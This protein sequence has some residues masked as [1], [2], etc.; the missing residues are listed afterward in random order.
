M[1]QMV[2]EPAKVSLQQILDASRF[3]YDF[4]VVKMTPERDTINEYRNDI[5]FVAAKHLQHGSG[6]EITDDLSYLSIIASNAEQSFD[7][8]IPEPLEPWVPT[9]FKFTTLADDTVLEVMV[10]KAA[11]VTGKEGHSVDNRWGLIIHPR[12]D[13]SHYL[14]FAKVVIEKYAEV[15]IS[16]GPDSIKLKR[17]SVSKVSKHQS[18]FKFTY[19]SN[20]NRMLHTLR[21]Y[22]YIKSK[23]TGNAVQVILSRSFCAEFNLCTNCFGY[24]TRTGKDCAGCEASGP[25]IKRKATELSAS[26][27]R[28]RLMAKNTSRGAGSSA[29]SAQ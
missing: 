5:A 25:G 18:S 14:D 23:G 12:K 21:D 9:H 13:D 22:K 26:A 20:F 1:T 4:K 29:P 16:I 8:A 19:T 6:D 3:F 24:N 15:G 27:Y 10:T 11:N 17:E 28:K 2:P 7:I